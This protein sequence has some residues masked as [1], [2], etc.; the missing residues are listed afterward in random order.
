[1]NQEMGELMAM[2]LACALIADF[3][4]LPALLLLADKSSLTKKVSPSSDPQVA[5]AE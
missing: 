2:T 5:A 1:M 3:L 4:L